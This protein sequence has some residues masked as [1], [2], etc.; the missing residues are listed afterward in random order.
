MAKFSK[1]DGKEVHYKGYIIGDCDGQ[2]LHFPIGEMRGEF[3]CYEFATRANLVSYLKNI[4]AKFKKHPEQFGFENIR[5]TEIVK[6]TL[7][8]DVA[9]EIKPIVPTVKRR[10]AKPDRKVLARSF[11]I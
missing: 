2:T 1:V 5:G 3:F 7:E 4:F 6:V 11:G 9:M 10:D 8:K